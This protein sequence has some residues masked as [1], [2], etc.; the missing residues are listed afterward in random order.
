MATH[1][2]SYL[3]NPMDRGAWGATVHGGH[4][5]SDTTEVTKQHQPTFFSTTKNTKNGI[6]LCAHR[7]S[8]GGRRLAPSFMAVIS[9][10]RDCGGGLLSAFLFPAFLAWDIYC[11]LNVKNFK[12][13]KAWRERKHLCMYYFC[14]LKNL[15]II[16]T[17]RGE[18]NQCPPPNR[19]TGT[20][21]TP[22]LLS[23][24]PSRTPDGKRPV[25]G[26]RPLLR[27]QLL[28]GQWPPGS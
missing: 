3:E 26:A 21:R 19:K 13:R 24:T 12:Y 11:F 6:S 8:P 22:P 15:L 10:R 28:A 1:S 7:H 17:M 5:E 14:H 9:G 25:D 20:T 18:K 2:Y 23:E 4:K 16:N 27:N